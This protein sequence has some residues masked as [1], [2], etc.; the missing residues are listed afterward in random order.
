MKATTEVTVAL[1]SRDPS[2]CGAN[3]LTQLVVVETDLHS[4]VLGDVFDIG[5]QVG[6]DLERQVS[7]GLLGALDPLTG[8]G[9]GESDTQR[10][11]DGLH[12]SRCLGLGNLGFGSFGECFEVFDTRLEVGI[13]DTGLEAELVQKGAREGNDKVEGRTLQ[14]SVSVVRLRQLQVTYTL[15]SK[16]S[17]PSS[18]SRSATCTQ[19]VLEKFCPTRRSCDQYLR[20]SV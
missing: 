10:L 20:P 13:I 18:P 17:F 6:E 5:G 2:H 7:E 14:L 11:S 12:P 16:S 3:K 4:L 8:V 1:V 15:A 19:T 9:L